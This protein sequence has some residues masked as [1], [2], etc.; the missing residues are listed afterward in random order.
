MRFESA[1]RLPWL[2]VLAAVLLVSIVSADVFGPCC[3]PCFGARSGRAAAWAGEDDKARKGFDF[4]GKDKKGGTP[5][6][7]PRPTSSS[8]PSTDPDDPIQAEILALKRWPDR[9]AT[10]AAESLFLRQKEAVP[11]LVRALD[12]K[13]PAVQPGAAWVLGQIGE[14]V[15]VQ[16]ILK[17]AAKRSNASRVKVFF[18]AAYG[19]GAGATKRWL[20][21]FLTVGNRPVF[22]GKSAD[23][24]A[25]K[26][27]ADDRDRVLYLLESDKS[28]VRVAGLKLLAPSGVEDVRERLVQALSDLSPSVSYA[29]ARLLAAR[30]DE[31]VIRR[32][33]TLAREAGARERAYAIIALV[34]VARANS[35]NPFE[36]TTVTEMAG[37]RGLLHPER[38]S[39]GASAAGLSYGAIDSQEQ[40]I[41]TLLDG[42]VV[43]TLIATL[44]G[45]HFRDY[46]SVTPS[47]FAALRKLTG[48][49]LPDTAVAWAQW[50]QTE[51]SDFRA[52][53]PLQGLTPADL[54]R[55]YVIFDAI[56]ANGRRKH[57]TFVP[58]GGAER[59]NAYILRRQVFEGLVA[60]LRD[61]GLF[62][63]IERG[64]VRASEHVAVTLGVMN[65]RKRMV[66]TAEVVGASATGAQ[67]N[68]RKYER[69]KMR[70]DALIDANVWQRYRDTD[71][72]PDAHTWW[73]T[74]VDTM[75]QA[76]PEERRALFQAAIVFAYDNL[77]GPSAR[78][79]A[80]Q[81]LRA[82]GGRLT[83]SEAEHLATILT[84][85]T[86]FGTME[87]DA[88]RWVLEQGYD[89]L[90]D[91]LAD[92]VAAREEK[93]AG[94]I[95]AGILL[96]GGAEK[97]RKA[98]ADERGAMRAA[99][100]HA[101]RL[102]VESDA[103]QRAPAEERR[104]VF[105]RLRPGLEVLSLDEDSAVSIRALIALAYLGDTH[106]VERLEKLYHAG[107]FNVKLEVTRA[108]GYVPDNSA[109]R[110][111]TRVMAEE[112]RDGKS[113]ALRIA[114]LE[115]MARSSHNDAVRLLRYY[116]LNDR[117]NTVRL[118]AGK[119]LADLGTDEAR[120][121]IV[122]HLTGGEPD[123]GRRALLVDVL[124]RFDSD[125]VPGLLRRYL[126]DKDAGVRAAAAL[127]AADHNMAEAFPFLL[128]ILRRGEGSLRERAVVSIANLTSMRF[129]VRGFAALADRYQAWFED[130]RIKGGTDRSWFREALRRKGYD[131]G[132]LAGY[133][134]EQR[135]IGAVA[136][137]AR[138]LRDD[139]PI[140]RRNA[141]VALQRLTGR[142]MGTVDRGTSVEEAAHV[143]DLWME[144]LKRRGGG[145]GR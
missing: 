6:D 72:W 84:S 24:L 90:R 126:A 110:L 121:S 2:H 28:A 89:D 54:P 51:R 122:E 64:G 117:D 109:H 74:N 76:S 118:A 71:K 139:D 3:G 136:L 10:R 18:K 108:L 34:E 41:S 43:D 52:R 102:F 101:A 143:A 91:A 61:E 13:D 31:N 12:G 66:V 87:A 140:F 50:W 9:R 42:R 62:E 80:L 73:R 57:V 14:E 144:W 141:A 135:G 123:A 106:V 30:A 94:E 112:R 29:A 23:F 134:K 47:I 107:N 25:D 100:A 58:D 40:S 120:F 96:E 83:R 86:A 11:Y 38:L 4:G 8:T 137:M 145:S 63:V 131:V 7:Q 81:R 129:D 27:N 36:E 113:G 53:R 79:E 130:P 97:L 49:D 59:P 103:T 1:P 37:P 93:A 119:V 115:A 26:V 19:L 77:P 128:Q 46:A 75:A 39:R 22:R 105:A 70:M 138:V 15:H 65:Q 92:S 142:S 16:V 35:S 133:L 5:A 104:R 20:I 98:F 33:N 44:G 116:L 95:L 48:R 127:R 68:V 124:G 17:A 55:A 60:F 56:E 45:A 21:S 99:A 88:L 78:R 67:E 125:V 85:G 111:L 132:P 69:L 32:L 114:A 82:L